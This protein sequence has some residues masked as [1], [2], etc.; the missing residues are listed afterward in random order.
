MVAQ[1]ISPPI[2]PS[3]P[4]KRETVAVI[5][6]IGE[7]NKVITDLYGL[8]QRLR[9]DL[10]QGYEAQNAFIEKLWGEV[11]KAGHELGEEFRRLPN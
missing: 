10:K 4:S 6:E 9:S 8:S 2:Q 11:K 3:L 5:R 7:T 1:T